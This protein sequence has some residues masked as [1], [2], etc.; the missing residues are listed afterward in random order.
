M[1]L[2][3]VVASSQQIAAAAPAQQIAAADSIR[4]SPNTSKS[5]WKSD[6]AANFHNQY[7][8][9][10]L[11]PVDQPAQLTSGDCDI[12]KNKPQ[13]QQ[14]LLSTSSTRTT[15]M[16]ADVS[17]NLITDDMKHN[18]GE[19]R[20]KI[21]VLQSRNPVQPASA[22]LKG[23]NIGS[24]WLAADRGSHDEESELMPSSFSAIVLTEGSKTAA[25]SSADPQA[26]ADVE[27]ILMREAVLAGDKRRPAAE[28]A[29]GGSTGEPSQAAG[30]LLRHSTVMSHLQD[31]SK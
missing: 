17:T 7:C 2:T 25:A 12:M 29:A 22:S 24:S 21:A 15:L 8:F 23:L 28:A 5:V 6:F 31:N 4:Q 27:Q 11:V 16:T 13:Q 26:G 9:S 20:S 14:Q 19:G 10:N 1:M 18:M 3:P 30:R